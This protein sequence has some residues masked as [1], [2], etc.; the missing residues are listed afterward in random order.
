M[1]QSPITNGRFHM[2]KKSPRHKGSQRKPEGTPKIDMERMCSDP[3]ARQRPE[4]ITTQDR[5]TYSSHQE[6]M[7]KMVF[8]H[9]VTGNNVQ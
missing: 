3:H 2:A 5:E 8:N 1:V 4:N 7:T 9:L 6:D